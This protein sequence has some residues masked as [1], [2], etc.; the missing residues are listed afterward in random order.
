M[1]LMPIGRKACH[2]AQL[3]L[4]FDA[5]QEPQ[6]QDATPNAYGV[7]VDH[8][9]AHRFA[10]PTKIKRTVARHKDPDDFIAL[11]YSAARDYRDDFI[12]LQIAR[13]RGRW[14]WSASSQCHHQYWGGAPSF[15]PQRIT[16]ASAETFD[17]ARQ[18]ALAYAT[19]RLS[20][21]ANS[22]ERGVADAANRLLTMIDTDDYQ[23]FIK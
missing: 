18:A 15:S 22:S 17:A 5:P 21:G 16:T 11:G 14:Y 8:C 10:A 2:D 20:Y 3:A 23:E 1:N 6:V 12:E 7:L 9:V 4:C 19:K 13:Y